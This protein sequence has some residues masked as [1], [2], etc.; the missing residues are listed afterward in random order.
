MLPNFRRT[1]VGT[2]SLAGLR[3]SRYQRMNRNPTIKRYIVGV[4]HWATLLLQL[5][6][7]GKTR[8]THLRRYK[9][10]AHHLCHFPLS[11]ECAS[12]CTHLPACV[13]GIE[14]EGPKNQQQNKAELRLATC[15]T[16]IQQLQ[17]TRSIRVPLTRV[18]RNH[19]LQIKVYSTMALRMW[20]VQ[21][22]CK[23]RLC[24]K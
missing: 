15:R 1:G 10:R 20:T 13:N 19:L 4:G 23:A 17:T 14:E 7:C 11:T 12:A 21:R 2:H 9:I 18:A 8:H 16:P 24:A 6:V 22:T 5:Q 3:Q